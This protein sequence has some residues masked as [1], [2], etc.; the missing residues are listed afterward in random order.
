MSQGFGANAMS[1]PQDKA[2]NLA[3]P[4]AGAATRQ[5][6]EPMDDRPARPHEETLALK[7]ES[8]R[9]RDKDLRRWVD[10]GLT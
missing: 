8:Y 3:R 5:W 1:R 4:G 6:R 9:L 7:G 10:R 2:K